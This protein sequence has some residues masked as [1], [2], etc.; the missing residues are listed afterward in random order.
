MDKIERQLR[1]AF[2]VYR[3]NP[4]CG[5]QGIYTRY[6]T[7]ELVELGHRVTVFSG[8]P[9]PILDEGVDLVPV[10]SLDLYRDADPFRTPALSEFHDYIDWLEYG[11]MLTAGFPEPR[12]FSLRARRM[13]ASRLGSFDIVHDNQSLGRGLLGMV[14]D[15]WPLVETVHHPITVDKELD[16]S[17]ARS[18]WRKVTLRR[19]YG[20]LAMQKRVASRLPR[21]ITVSNNSKVDIS[22]QMGVD[23]K[24]ISVVP[25]GVD[26][27]VFRPLEGRVRRRA[28]IMTTAS[29]DVPMKGLVPLLEALAKLR[30]EYPSVEL[31]VVGRLKPESRAAVAIRRLGLDGAVSFVS[32]ITDHELVE[33]YAESEVAVVPS[34]YE[35]FSLPA[36]EA[37][38][39]GVPLVTT[40]GGALPEVVGRHGHTALLV[41][42]N[43][44]DALATAI[45]RLLSN[46]QLRDRLGRAGRQRVLNRFTWRITAE[47]TLEQYEEVLGSI[48]HNLRS[49]ATTTLP[50]L[51]RHPHPVLNEASNSPV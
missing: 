6:L 31:N 18:F 39:C 37:M 19:W 27:T 23:L 44:P 33:M 28:R 25:V 10:P 1:I 34:L 26:H 29:A 43:D 12:T 42:P 50:A 36:I 8:P 7:R 38:A 35:G 4:Q 48:S 46:A 22:N 45:G 17:H 32:G 15:G 16:L 21:I 41:P 13:L 30:A 9:Y 49:S 14:K 2:L 11:I 3:G 40:T 51:S 24:K 47:K 20:F 5:G